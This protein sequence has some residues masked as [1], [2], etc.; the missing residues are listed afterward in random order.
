MKDSRVTV[1]KK[2]L[3]GL[4][5]SLDAT[6][7]VTR[8]TGAETIPEP[9]KESAAHLIVRL[10]TAD[11]LASSKFNGSP[12][13]VA[14]VNTMLGAMRRLDAAYVAYNRHSKGSPGER[15][16]AAMT[17]DAEIHGARSDAGIHA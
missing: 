7:R 16:D 4:L 10:G 17:L 12:L 6:L 11:R 8:W 15:E 1:F 3:E 5:E 9:L 13:D 2:T 14:K